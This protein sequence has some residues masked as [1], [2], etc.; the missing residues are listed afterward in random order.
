V[1]PSIAR[2]GE[3]VGCAGDLDGDNRADVFVA[4]ADTVGR[5]DVRSAGMN[6]DFAPAAVTLSMPD[7]HFGRAATAADVN[8][9]GFS[10][11][12][13]AAPGVGFA[14]PMVHAYAGRASGVSTT[15]TWSVGSP[16]GVAGFAQHVASL[17]DLNRDGTSELATGGAAGVVYLE[18]SATAPSMP[19]STTVTR[20]RVAAVAGSIGGL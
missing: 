3:V 16:P 9:D 18:S 13:V 10:D 11:L 20:A 6:G 2:F 14:S 17:G 4:G 8:A 7:V 15:A 19:R 12:V 1:S 5:L